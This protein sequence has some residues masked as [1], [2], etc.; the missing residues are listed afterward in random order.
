MN[1]HHMKC[2]GAHLIRLPEESGNMVATLLLLFEW[3]IIIMIYSQFLK[4]GDTFINE[5]ET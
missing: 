5:N 2:L 1:W 4:H 3:I